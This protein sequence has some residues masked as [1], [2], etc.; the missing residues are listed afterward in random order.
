MPLQTKFNFGAL[1]LTINAKDE[2]DLFQQVSIFGEI[3]CLC[4]QC[5]SKNVFP[6]HRQTQEKDD[7]YGMRCRECGAIFD[8]GQKKAG[9]LFPKVNSERRNNKKGWYYFEEQDFSKD[10]RGGG[11]DHTDDRAQRGRRDDPPR[12]G[13]GGR[14]EASPEDTDEIPF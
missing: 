10:S 6:T 2:M 7:Y 11:R 3:P 5:D 12:G 4:G 8:V 13:G 1:L 9:G 14:R